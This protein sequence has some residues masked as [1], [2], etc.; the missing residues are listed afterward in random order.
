MLICYIDESGTPEIPGTTSHFVLAG[1]ALPVHKWKECEVAIQKCKANFQLAN[2]EIHVGWLIKPYPEQKHISNF[3]TLSQADRVREVN[4]FRNANLLKLQSN[5][6]ASKQYHNTKK[7]YTKTKNY[8]H[9]T[10]EER[11]NFVTEISKLIGSW[12]FCRLFADCIDKVHFDPTKHPLSIASQSFEQV[13]SRFEKY[14]QTYSKSIGGKQYG[15]IVH[16]NN[17]T[18]AKK[19]TELMKEFHKMG[20]SWVSINNIIETPLFV[21]SQ[22]TSM[23]QIADVCSYALRRYI[24]N[25]ETFLFDEI[26]KIADKTKTG[27]VVGIRHFTSNSCKCLICSNHK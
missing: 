23:V 18:V 17:Q 11:K 24:E 13:I 12:S 4:R 3:D 26:F 7:T 15:L 6:K 19:V 20:T 14:L 8:I 1:F 21:D 9:L 2:A 16:D 27:K 5:P 10:F 25:S 22:L